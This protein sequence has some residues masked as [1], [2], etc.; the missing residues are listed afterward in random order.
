MSTY[1]FEALEIAGAPRR[2]VLSVIMATGLLVGR[3]VVSITY[4]F[5]AGLQD[6]A[7]DS[8]DCFRRFLS[9]VKLNNGGGYVFTQLIFELIDYAGIAV[10]FTLWA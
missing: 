10:F 2:A 7:K 8:N 3:W 4:Y 1:Y 9:M 6:N 5:A